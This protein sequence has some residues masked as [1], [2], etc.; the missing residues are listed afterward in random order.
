MSRGRYSVL[1]A[2]VCLGAFTLS[3]CG[4]GDDA[5]ERVV[6]AGP[7]DS[8][9]PPAPAPAP[10]P[11]PEPEPEPGP[12]PGLQGP[13]TLQDAPF[14][15]C[16]NNEVCTAEAEAAPP[17][18]YLYIEGAR[19]VVNPTTLAAFPAFGWVVGESHGR[20]FP[21]FIWQGNRLSGREQGT[22]YQVVSVVS[23][24]TFED[25][26]EVRLRT[27]YPGAGPAVLT[28]QRLPG[29]VLKVALTPP[30]EIRDAG[31]AVTLLTLD[32]PRDE[33]LFGLGAR[34]DYFNQR[35]KLRNVWTEQQNTGLGGLA[36]LDLAG[37]GLPFSLP[38]SSLLDWLGI[39]PDLDDLALLEPRTSFPNG[40]QAAYWVE[41]FVTGSRGWSAW[42]PHTHL[43]R[44]DLAA[45]RNDK[46][47]WQVV[48]SDD[49]TL[50]FADG[51]IEA[52]SRAY[53]EYWGRAP[54]PNSNIYYPW[55]DTLN[56]GEGE[57]APNGQ[58]FW[59]G[60]R[61]RCDLLRFVDRAERYDI[62]FKM[63]GVEGWQVVPLG[64][65]DVQTESD[66][67]ICQQVATDAAS[68]QADPLHF[69]EGTNARGENFFDYLIHERDYRLAGYWN[70]FT[71]DPDCPSPGQCRGTPDVPLDS[72]TAFYQARD[73]DYFVTTEATGEDHEVT[74]NRGGVSRILDF[75]HPG[76]A[77]YWADQI[78]RMMDLGIDTFMHDFG[79]L[80]TDDMAFSA[81]T[82]LNR[83]HNLYARAYQ[84]AGR[85]AVER[86]MAEN[87]D[88]V[89]SDFQ[90]FFY[91]RAGITGSCAATPGVFPGDESTSWDAGHGLPSVI[92]AMLNLSLS[93]CYLFTTDIGGYFD[94]TAPR[95]REDLFIRWSQLAALTPI[96][97]IHSATFNG[98]V[99]PWTWREGDHADPA[100]YDTVDIFRR[101][102]RLKVA[103]VPLIQHWVERAA[104]H[105]DI[106]PVRPLI[107][108]DTSDQAMKVDYQWLLGDDLLVAPVIQ[109]DAARQ[110]VYFPHGAQWQRVVVNDQGQLRGTGEV[111]S[112]GQTRT[113][114][115][116]PAL[117]DIPLFVRCG[118]EMAFLPIASGWAECAGA[119]E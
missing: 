69:R 45:T 2:L 17:S 5:E 110:A 24:Q 79:E 113:V 27:N 39:N 70:F 109:E 42:T 107:L 53:T 19:P 116:D 38:T 29:G 119:N 49:V 98:S 92:P 57:A 3:G 94:F 54:L 103:L 22:L 97:R 100:R 33:G 66:E 78:A 9:E 67:A 111:F 90:P 56:Q 15:L 89:R 46:L 55:I 76:V 72:K 91:A 60:E 11:E 74:T 115:L 83:I 36:Y 20:V 80:T 8:G 13:V 52:S 23:Q 84:Q 106:G 12:S 64:H 30:A 99:Y 102:A 75:T 1:F 40:A 50:L 61:A 93:G 14:R 48:G 4:G 34:K 105:G 108:E 35:G 65:P 112:G 47:R 81:G 62:P 82:D 21:S 6:N 41:A 59:G 31:I 118:G 25:R 87:R 58:G 26:T 18:P 104:R 117:R 16:L 43:Q 7:P 86:Y 51:G 63:L 85:H 95:T 32:S 114:S 101:Y 96:M 73:Q 68:Y 88:K 77:D 37:V 10:E 44:L 71:T 28:L